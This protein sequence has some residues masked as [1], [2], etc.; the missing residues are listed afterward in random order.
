[1]SGSSTTDATQTPRRRANTLAIRLWLIA[2]MIAAV[3]LF[4]D[5]SP[6]RA[7]GTV[8]QETPIT[9]TSGQGGPPNH[10]WGQIFTPTRPELVA[11]D[12]AWCTGAGRPEPR[13]ITIRPTEVTGVTA[14]GPRG[15]VVDPIL[16]SATVEL[17]G[18]PNYATTF[19]HVHFDPPAVL[20]PGQPYAITMENATICGN[21][22][23]EEYPGGELFIGGSFSAEM[24]ANFPFR[25]Y[26]P[27]TTPP[28]TTPPDTTIATSPADPTN[29]TSASFAFTATETGSTFQCSLDAG[30]YGVCASPHGYS[31]LAAGNHTF[32]VRAVDPTG[33]VDQSEATF[34]WQIDLTPPSVSSVTGIPATS[35]W[36][37]VGNVTISFAASE[38]GS[39]FE[40]KLDAEAFAACTNPR[41]YTGLSD[42]VHTFQVRAIDPAGNIGTPSAPAYWISFV[43]SD[44][45]GV[46]DS[47]DMGTRQFSDLAVTVPNAGTTAG[48]ILPIS[49]VT[50]PS[51]CISNPTSAHFRLSDALNTLMPALP[52][53]ATR[54]S[55]VTVET[56]ELPSNQ[57]L[58]LRLTGS[59]STIRFE[60]NSR[61]VVTDPDLTTTL[62]VLTGAVDVV[63]GGQT[64]TLSVGPGGTL[65]YTEHVA[66]SGALMSLDID[67]VTGPV[68]L[69]GQPV[70]PGTTLPANSPPTVGAGGPYTGTEGAPIAL[71]GTT[72][73]PD[74]DAVTISWTVTAGAG[75]D[76]GSVCQV[77]NGT[78]LAPTIT[79]NDDGS[80]TSRL[81]VSDG[82]T[83]PV[84][85]DASVTVTNAAPTISAVVGPTNAVTGV[86][87]TFTGTVSDPS[88]LDTTAGFSWQW[89][90]NGGA[91]LPFGVPN[92]N[93]FKVT[94]PTCGDQT[95]SAKARDDDGGVSTPVP[96]SVVKAYD[97]R[98]EQPL[99]EG[100]NNVVQKGRVVPVTISVGCGSAALAGLSPTIALLKGD[101]SPGTETAAD[102]V[103]AYSSSAADTTGVMRASGGGYMYNLRAPDDV[104]VKSGTKYTIRVRPFGDSNLEAAKY[105][106]LVIK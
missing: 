13:T 45:D 98:F 89:A 93:T 34:S 33:N 37:V 69:N 4:A 84:T 106:V 23:Q 90:T 36:P 27:A 80:Y 56:F 100:V 9:D 63:V 32:R 11:V 73:D 59:T 22:N 102:E 46:G 71:V 99:D 2:F 77:T 91:Y 25:T 62:E 88:S 103:E 12:V 79:C 35:A 43:D 76:S 26:A 14:A 97:L 58:C 17:P 94:F 7:H 68:T 65:T 81:T 18:T 85:S 64:A 75:T 29:S 95:V 61:A 55:G 57:K 19:T 3:I 96:T 48:A 50:T 72:T 70:T 87:T 10:R 83:A 78:T 54:V 51:S 92:A 6:V 39:T 74:G 1:M 67:L 30:A 60:P 105:I 15:Y 42:G 38:A 101:V 104:T 24:P 41:T 86:A 21:T 16:A 44:G 5:A 53:K 8:D 66:A 20:T 28:D 31:G 49:G 82:K 40:C 52:G 47:I